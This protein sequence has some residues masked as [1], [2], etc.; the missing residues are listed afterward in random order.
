MR[1]MGLGPVELMLVRSLWL[2]VIEAKRPELCP[3]FFEVDLAPCI[4]QFLRRGDGG[5]CGELMKGAY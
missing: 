4:L 1:S 3:A 5:W 2:A